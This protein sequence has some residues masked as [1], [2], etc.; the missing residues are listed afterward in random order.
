MAL[1]LYLAMTSPEITSIDHYPSHCAYM[2]CHFS[3]YS[4]GLSNLPD[5]LAEGAMLILND[6]FPCQGHSPSLVVQQIASII[7]QFRCESLLLDFQRPPEPE[8]EVMAEAI[9]QAAPCPAA[10]TPPFCRDSVFLPPCPLHIPLEEY[11]LPWKQREVWLEEALCQEDVVI[12]RDGARFIPQFP[13]EGL[14]GGFYD[15]ALRCRYKIQTAEDQIT[16]TLFD[17]PESLEKKLE[18]AQSLGVSRAVGLWQELGTVGSH[19]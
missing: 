4:Q 7:A 12:T 8:S 18:L 16:F 6:N 17:T 19:V 13:P 10:A 5:S 11:L 1:P 3:P 2:A 9:L 14:T 15:E